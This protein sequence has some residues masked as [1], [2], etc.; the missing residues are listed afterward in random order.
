MM[1]SVGDYNVFTSRR[2]SVA[3]ARWLG[4]C[5]FLRSLQKV[6]QWSWEVYWLVGGFVSW[7]AALWAFAL[8]Q[9]KDVVDVLRAC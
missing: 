1:L 8:I 3:L 2:I 7:I 5:Q 6:R 4:F 9:T